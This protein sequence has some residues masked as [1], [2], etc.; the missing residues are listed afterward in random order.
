MKL[1]KQIPQIR[2][3]ESP[4]LQLSSGLSFKAMVVIIHAHL[5]NIAKPGTS[6]QT[7]KICFNKITFQG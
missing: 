1:G 4:I 6:G 2:Q 5:D 3:Q 7:V